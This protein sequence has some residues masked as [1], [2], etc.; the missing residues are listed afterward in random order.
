M[1]P[2]TCI[3]GAG[4][5]GLTYAAG[6]ASKGFH[7]NLVDVNEA[8]IATVNRGE[9]PIDEPGMA[10][11]F[12]DSVKKG[13]IHGTTR[14]ENVFLPSDLFLV[15]VGT[16]CDDAGNINLAQV[17]SV[18]RGLRDCYNKYP[19]APYKVTCIKSTVICGTTDSVVLPAIEESGKRAGVDFGIAMSPEFLK[20]GSALDDI[21]HP[22]KIV[23]GGIDQRS[24]DGVK[25]VLASFLGPGEE[26]KIIET[27]VRTAELIKYAQNAFL[28]TKISFINEIARFAEAFGVDVG[29]VARAM[30]MDSRIS[31]KFLAAGPGFG[32]SCFPKDVRALFSAGKKAGLEPL[33]LKAVLDVNERQ[34]QHV[35]SLLANARPVQGLNVAVLGLAFKA[36]T[37]DTRES[38]SR[39]VVPG[40]IAAGALQVRVHD[41]SAYAREEFKKDFPASDRLSYHDRIEDALRGA[42]ACI[43]LT[44][45]P[46]YKRLR[47]ADMAIMAARPVVIDSRRLLPPSEFK[48]SGVE[49]VTLG[50]SASRAFAP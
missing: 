22:D 16:Y 11:A 9:S 12:N 7:V 6:L 43:I 28:A 2:V 20:E 49:L 34:K 8:T 40:L 30:G 44:E 37:G 46:E 18:A 5:V 38:V 27:D 50:Q 4:Y 13:L 26:S 36:D 15:C 42:D 3:I 45:W 31:P 48:G 25:Q 10:R 14:L 39:T 17:R 33:M 29:T 41:P 1:T 23:I 24:I 47:P 19:S 35:L 32:G 21:L